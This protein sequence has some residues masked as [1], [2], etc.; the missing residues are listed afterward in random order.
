[1]RRAPVST[2]RAQT[3]TPPAAVAKAY[4][5]WFSRNFSSTSF[6][7]VISVDDP[8]TMCRLPVFADDGP[9][10]R[11]QP[12][13]PPL[14]IGNRLFGDESLLQGIHDFQIHAS[15]IFDLLLRC[16]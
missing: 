16:D 12:A 4:C 8:S 3:L 15:K 1:M 13:D 5:L 6:R 14:S 7:W 2:S 11:L 10:D 9:L